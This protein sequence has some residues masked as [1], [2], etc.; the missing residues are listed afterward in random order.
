MDITL[1]LSRLQ[2]PAVIAAIALQATIA[3]RFG[4]RLGARLSER[5]RETAEKTAG[6]A[7]AALGVYLLVAR[8]TIG[9][10]LNCGLG[11]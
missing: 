1:G 6:I 5:L 7:L 4:L 3:A 10:G 2:V 9:A 11:A 8:L